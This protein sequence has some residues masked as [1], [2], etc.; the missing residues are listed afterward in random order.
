MKAYF[1][2]EL[3]RLFHGGCLEIMPELEGISIG[4]M[5]ADAPY[6]LS[7]MGKKW[8]YDVPSTEIWKEALRILKPGSHALIFAGSRTQH[9][10]AVNVE[11]AGFI[12]KDCLIS[13]GVQF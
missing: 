11:D 7:F 4:A 1:E 10:M 12:L 6:G 13:N 5:L 2:T 9:R 3:G 8:D